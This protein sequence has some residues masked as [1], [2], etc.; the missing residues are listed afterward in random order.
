M[1]AAR[2]CMELSVFVFRRVLRRAVCDFFRVRSQPEPESRIRKPECVIHAHAGRGN[3]PGI[4]KGAPADHET[5]TGFSIIV[6]VRGEVGI[7]SAS[8]RDRLERLR[9]EGQSIASGLRPLMMNP[10]DI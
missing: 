9:I 1:P 10:N 6:E 3:V 5:R 4:R 8:Y 2:A 7:R